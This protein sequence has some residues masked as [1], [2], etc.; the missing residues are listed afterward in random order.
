MT[1]KIDPSGYPALDGLDDYPVRR[2]ESASFQSAPTQAQLRQAD[3]DQAAA[4]NAHLAA[5][6][7]TADTLE[8][9]AKTFRERNA[10]YGSNYK[11]VG[12][13]MAI[14]FPNGVTPAVL[15]SDQFHLFEL[16][17]VK[18]SRLAIS[19]LQHQDSAHDAGVYC[20]MIETII[21]EL[22]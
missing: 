3:I 7:T 17:I 14:F 2:N 18:L 1:L 6:P 19:D 21:K 20:A 8:A 11:M 16:V 4:F 15:S 13:L 10:V 5:A 12:K 22:K 9:M